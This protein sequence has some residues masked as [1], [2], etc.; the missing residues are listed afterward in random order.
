VKHSFTI[1]KHGD[2]TIK[3]MAKFESKTFGQV[4]EKFRA[5]AKELGFNFLRKDVTLIG[6]QFVNKDTNETLEAVPDRMLKEYLEDLVKVAT[7]DY[8]G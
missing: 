6:G 7:I 1:L 5:L 3:I 4:Q 2:G 8:G